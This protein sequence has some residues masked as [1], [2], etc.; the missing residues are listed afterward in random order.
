[1]KKSELNSDEVLSK[2]NG[3]FYQKIYRALSK[4]KEL[5]RI[6]EKTRPLDLTLTAAI[7]ACADIVGAHIIWEFEDLPMPDTS[8]HWRIRFRQY[9]NRLKQ[10]SYPPPI[11]L[12]N[13]NRTRFYDAWN[14]MRMTN[15]QYK[16]EFLDFRLK[17]ETDEPLSP[18]D[19]FL[20]HSKSDLFFRAEMLVQAHQTHIPIFSERFQ[21]FFL[22][23]WVQREV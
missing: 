2:L 15:F 23:R 19:I 21:T 16:F 9:E 17:E 7:R 4:D 20:N 22:K 10:I 3:D 6:I 11:N 1:M 12:E 14:L 13:Y 8:E 18:A 5:V